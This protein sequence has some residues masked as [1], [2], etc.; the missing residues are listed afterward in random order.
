VWHNGWGAFSRVAQERSRLQSQA[1]RM[2][3]AVAL[4]LDRER[5]AVQNMAQRWPVSLVRDARRQRQ[6]LDHLAQRLSLLDP[7]L[8]L[9]RGYAWL[10]DEHGHAVTSVTQTHVGQALRGVLADGEVGLTVN[11]AKP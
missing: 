11:P 9:Q 8:V 3:R 6:Q 1:H 4:R 7:T 10:A 2:A 5:G